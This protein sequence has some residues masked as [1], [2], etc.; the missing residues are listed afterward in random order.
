MGQGLG[1]AV[2]GARRRPLPTLLAIGAIGVSLVLFGL[3]VLALQ[4]LGRVAAPWGEGVQ[5]V[6][7]LDADASPERARAIAQVLGKVDAVER[8]DY[9]APDEALAR[10]RTSLGPRG[11][12]LDGVETGYLPASLE[13]TL[14]PGV[15][16]VA[17]ASPLVAKLRA[18]PGV[19]EVEFL[20]D[21]VAKV[22][23]LHR[24]LRLI[25]LGLALAVALACVYVVAGTITLGVVARKDEIEVLELVGATDRFVRWPLVVEGAL[26]GL[27]GAGLA[28]LLLLITYRL[29]APMIEGALAGALGELRFA[30]LPAAQ[31]GLGLLL[32]TGLGML[33]SLLALGRRTRHV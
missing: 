22:A 32:G 21:W 8:V 23:A 7:Y 17:E 29:G 24:A 14:A 12:L 2:G 15:R 28:L 3:V 5:M 13:L 4:N 18:T 26:Q 20:G 27:F 10:L 19:E 31:I 1:R 9:V 30:F 33:G 16:E 25:A 6:V 11:G